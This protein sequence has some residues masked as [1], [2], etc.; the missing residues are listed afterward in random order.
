MK[1]LTFVIDACKILTQARKVPSSSSSSDPGLCWVTG[2]CSVPAGV[3]LLLHLQLLQPRNGEDGGD[4]AADGGSGPS[5]QR[6]AD[7]AW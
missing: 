6:S 3:G 7:P 1:S 2:P 5:H 4:G